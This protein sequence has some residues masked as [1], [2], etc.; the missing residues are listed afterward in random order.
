MIKFK[1]D[2]RTW[3]RRCGKCCSTSLYCPPSSPPPCTA[4]HLFL[5]VVA[6]QDGEGQSQPQEQP[7]SCSG[8]SPTSS[9]FR[10][11]RWP[12]CPLGVPE[13][14]GKEG[15]ASGYCRALGQEQVEK[16]NPVY[17]KYDTLWRT[18]QE[19]KYNLFYILPRPPMSFIVVYHIF[20]ENRHFQ[21]LTSVEEE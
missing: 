19:S 16:D 9:S 1:I 8:S 20:H 13:N 14:T 12:W 4:T 10:R 7:S 2:N 11:Q 6:S 5:G 21:P 15:G 18:D 17:W 3:N